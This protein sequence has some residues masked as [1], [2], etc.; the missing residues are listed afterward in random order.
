MSGGRRH[1]EDVRLVDFAEVGQVDKRPNVDRKLE[2]DRP[3]DVYVE[4]RS[5]RTL[6]RELV[7]GLQSLLISFKLLGRN[8]GGRTLAREMHMKH[9][10]IK[11]PVMVTW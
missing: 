9:T 8:K 10:L 6:L 11:I 7:D 4:D 3:D 2:K 1:T 5:E